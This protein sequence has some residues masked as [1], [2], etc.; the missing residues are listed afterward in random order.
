MIGNT[1]AN[2]K[3]G[4]KAFKPGDFVP[5]PRARRSGFKEAFLS[6]FGG[7]IKHAKKDG[8]G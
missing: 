3:P 7:R 4:A 8:K 5:K 1:A 2:R 6:A